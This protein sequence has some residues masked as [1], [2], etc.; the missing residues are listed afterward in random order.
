MSDSLS[1]LNCCFLLRA[2]QR[3]S[4]PVIFSS[5]SSSSKS[6]KSLCSTLTQGTKSSP[7]DPGAFRHPDAHFHLIFITRGADPA[8]R[9]GKGSRS[10]R[11]LLVLRLGV[12]WTEL[13][14]SLGEVDEPDALPAPCTRLNASTSGPPEGEALLEIRRRRS[15][16][17]E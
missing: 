9:S 6:W 14:S 7:L 3:S 8:T 4:S 16:M 10:G 13:E 2:A 5:R 12:G 11:L 1:E 17:T 15:A